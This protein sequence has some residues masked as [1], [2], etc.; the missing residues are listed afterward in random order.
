MLV[1]VKRRSFI[2]GLIRLPGEVFN[3]DDSSYSNLWAEKVSKGAKSKPVKQG[4]YVP[5]EIPSLIPE[6]QKKEK[7]KE[8]KTASK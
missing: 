2:G 7:T 4:E 8:K 5:L 6:L 1:R 3:C